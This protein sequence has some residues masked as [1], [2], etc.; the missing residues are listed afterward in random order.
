MEAAL[1]PCRVSD[2]FAVPAIHTPKGTQYHTF[3]YHLVSSTGRCAQRTA[4]LLKPSPFLPWPPFL[5]SPGA[6]AFTYCRTWELEAQLTHAP[7]A[8]IHEALLR[9][10]TFMGGPEQE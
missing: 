5:P 8:A 4:S 7:R 10:H 6:A 9:P 1:S 2:F 3:A